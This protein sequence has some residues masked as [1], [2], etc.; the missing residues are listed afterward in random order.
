M[1]KNIS[2]NISGI[3]F[4]IEEDG[5]ESLRKYLDSINRYFG[6]FED[7]SEILADIESRIAEIFLS[8]LN[9]G[10]QVITLEDVNSLIAT[11][12]N[13]NDFK[14][15]EEQEIGN[16]SPRAEHSHQESNARASASDTA[17]KKLFR[18]EK[19]KIL[20]GVCA[21]LGHYFSIDPV[22][23][24]VLF[25]L[26]V[27]GSYG[28]LLLAYIILWI[29]IPNSNQLPDDASIKKMYRDPEKK[30]L[31]G[32]ASGVAAFFGVDITVIR[33]LFI[34]F[35]FLG[36]LGLLLYII[37]WIALPQANSITEKMEMQGEPVTLSNIESTV[38][39]SLNEKEEE[40]STLAK[41]V[42]FPFRLIATFITVLGKIL[43]P[44][45]KVLVEFIRVVFGL[46]IFF[47]G[48]ALLISIVIAGGML[49]GF[50]TTSILPDYWGGGEI[51][52]LSLPAE[53]IRNTFPVW[54]MVAAFT[55]ILIPSLA[56]LLSGSSIIAKRSLV[57]QPVS[58][59]MLGLFVTSILVLSFTV[60]KM[61]YS[62]K[63]EGEF[64]IE[65]TFALTGKTPILKLNE[66]G[67]DNYN[68]TELNLKG[69]EGSELKLVQRFKSQGFSRKNGSEN[70]QMVTYAVLEKDSSLVFDSNI[71]FKKDAKF[72]AQRLEMDL[73]IPYGQT[74][75]IEEEL[76]RIIEN[77]Y[78]DYD[79]YRDSNMNKIWKMTD[80]GFECT[81]CSEPTET[82]Q[83]QL[84]DQYGFKD[85]SEIEMTG[86]FDLVI[87]RG[88]A[89]SVQLDGSQ[90]EKR[91]YEVDANGETLEIRFRSRSNTFWE[92]DFDQ[93]DRVKINITLP[94]L[95]KLKIKGAGQ[96]RI[97]GF[98]EEEMDIT[99]LGAMTGDADLRARNLTLDLAGP[100]VLQLDGEGHFLN[101]EVKKLSQLKA[102]QYQV[103][104]AVIEAKGMGR[105]RVNA[106]QS[107]DIDTDA[108]SSVKYVGEPRVTRRD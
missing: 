15:A 61:V 34:V 48:L 90:K 12:G 67:M 19:R 94:H 89:Y 18:D 50:F 57:N 102:G 55:I 76:W 52:G 9:E 80:H 77:D 2:I 16:D 22:W 72:R 63:E 46:A 98:D 38:K 42:L 69:Y 75:L 6:S 27:L 51:Q 59:V 78:R 17:H 49:L 10:K 21:G 8:R 100:M 88:D 54:S 24:R 86:I 30:V 68:V 71:S 43:G 20:G 45:V 103:E 107:V 13:V 39:K 32:V 83:L 56:I 23:P 36:G 108:V 11:M 3:I 85:F 101:A 105:A 95:T 81:N 53:A 79:G 87:A 74:F 7:S 5:Y 93:E 35:A 70:A 104:D 28:G 4:H 47:I 65:K 96:F 64:K 66:V 25:A 60:P 40:E 62:F 44:L 92:K 26:L 29:V 73:F 41:I 33:V 14:A 99:L 58:W 82:K 84:N 97:R 1:K 106:S 31:G 91:K 37:L